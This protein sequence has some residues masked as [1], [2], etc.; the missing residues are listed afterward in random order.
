MKHYSDRIAQTYQRAIHRRCRILLAEI[1]PELVP[2]YH[3]ALVDDGH[4]VQVV[5]DGIECLA[6]LRQWR[7]DL[8]ILNPDLPWGYGDGVLACMRA[9]NLDTRVMLVATDLPET[10]LRG[11]CATLIHGCFLQPLPGHLLVDCVQCILARAGSRA[12]ELSAALAH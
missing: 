7:P 10:L 3:E 8:L 6:K 9:E 12:E 4:D 5:P 2:E 11:D 1:D